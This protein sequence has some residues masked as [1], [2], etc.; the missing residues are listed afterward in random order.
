MI[1]SKQIRWII[2]FSFTMSLICCRTFKS[3]P[4]PFYQIKG[5]I[6]EI[7]TTEKIE[8]CPC[9]FF[10]SIKTIAKNEEIGLKILLSKKYFTIDNENN[11][12]YG[13]EYQP[14]KSG[15]I[16]KISSINIW[17]KNSRT[18][19]SIDITETLFCNQ[20]LLDNS[21]ERW[22]NYPKENQNITCYYLDSS[23][24]YRIY[25]TYKLTNTDPYN[26]KSKQGEYFSKKINNTNEY[27]CGW[28]L[29]SDSLNFLQQSFFRS[30]EDFKSK[31]NHNRIPYGGEDELS[32]IFFP[33]EKLPINDYNQVIFKLN[34]EDNTAI[35][36]INK[37]NPVNSE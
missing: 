23:Q 15:S 29:E 33:K 34:F 5:D 21:N 37:Y 27:L 22:K 20:T 32:L 19:D 8:D 11:R 7:I 12:I 24:N 30:I 26:S 17:L 36:L 18:R 25:H 6:L 3:Q 10:K 2:I 16:E 28:D 31:F 4:Y 35:E 1:S 14:G 9:K 13:R